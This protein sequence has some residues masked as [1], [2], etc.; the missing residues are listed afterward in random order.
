MSVLAI[1]DKVPLTVG[2]H[3]MMVMN[4]VLGMA[5][6]L[7]GRRLFWL[8]VAAVGFVAGASLV[9]QT[10][11]PEPEW[12]VMVVAL[13]MGLI[14]ALLSVFLQRVMVTLAGVIAG[15]YVAYTQALAFHLAAPDWVPWLAGGI[16]GG[17][18]VWIVFDVALIVLSAVSGATIIVQN[19]SID[20]RAAGWVFLVLCLVGL[21]V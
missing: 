3:T 19:V 12:V 2:P 8:L 10:L 21:V 1:V 9:T 13:A 20:P 6:L 16:L 11:G 14:G 15:G 4:I 7:A 18:L 17:L 5:L